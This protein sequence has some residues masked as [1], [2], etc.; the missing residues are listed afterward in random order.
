MSP[1]EQLKAEAAALEA[2]ARSEGRSLRH[3]VALERVAR[4][5]GYSNWRACLAAQRHA[6][7]A[8]KPPKPA[9]PSLAGVEMERYVNLEWDFSIDIPKRWNAFPALPSSSPFEIIR[10]KS[11]EDGTHKL[12]VYRHPCDPAQ[13]PQ[14]RSAAL[15]RHLAGCSNFT[16]GETTIGSRSV[17]TLDFDQPGEDVRWRCRSYTIFEDTLGYRLSFASTKWDAMAALF[18]RMAK[19]FEFSME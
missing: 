10:F 11:L 7:P 4:H 13:T 17:T 3:C 2:R 18:E 6:V 9:A 14:E 8:V 16:G 15:Q 5:H 19:S 1:I 12:T